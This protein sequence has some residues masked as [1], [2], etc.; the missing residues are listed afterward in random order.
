MTI[1]GSGFAS[2]SALTL[3]LANEPLG[4]TVTLPDGTFSAE[5]SVPPLP[6]DHY[7]LDAIDA[8]GNIGLEVVTITNLPVGGEAQLPQASDSSSPNRIALAAVA[9]GV[10]L[11]LTA[12][13]WY[14]ARR[15]LR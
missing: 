4:E 5:A 13:A 3:L 6:V 8:E 11:T 2:S 14:A 15:R 12:V 7:L 9:A 10:L 1:T